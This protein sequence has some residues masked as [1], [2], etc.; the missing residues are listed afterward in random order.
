MDK[1]ESGAVCRRGVPSGKVEFDENGY[2]SVIKDYAKEVYEQRRK[3]KRLLIITGSGISKTPSIKK[4]M[5]KIQELVCSQQALEAYSEAFQRI[6]EEYDAC[7]RDVGADKDTNSGGKAAS[8]QVSAQSKLLTYIQNAYLSEMKRYVEKKDQEALKAVWE[9]FVLWLIEGDKKDEPGLL[10]REP[11]KAHEVIREMYREM[12]AVS[13]TTNFDNM[14]KK[15]FDEKPEEDESFYPLLDTEDFKRY[16][17]SC[18]RE[19]DNRQGMQRTEIQSRGDVFWMRCSG[20]KNRTCKNIGRQC[21]VPSSDEPPKDGKIVCRLCGSPVEI[22]FAFPGTKEKDHEMSRVMSGMWRFLALRCGAVLVVGSS[23]D[24]DPVLLKFLRE[25]L[26]REE[27]P[28]LYVSRRSVKDG[29]QKV[30]ENTA[31]RS[32]FSSWPQREE[33][34][35]YWVCGSDASDVLT[36]VLAAYREQKATGDKPTLAKQIEKEKR[37]YIGYAK[38]SMA[39]GDHGETAELALPVKKVH[40]YIQ[41]LKRYSQLGMKTYW[42]SAEKESGYP[43]HNRYKHS[44]GVAMTATAIYYAARKEKA[45]EEER[46][47]L[48]LAALLHDLGHLPFSHLIEEVFNEFG[49]VP[50]G[51]S[52]TFDHE[53]YTRVRIRQL[54]EDDLE[55][56][57]VLRRSGYT[58]TDLLRLIKGEFGVGYLDAIINGPVDADKIEYLF[59]DGTFTKRSHS[60]LFVNFL[61]DYCSELD[62]TEHGFLTISGNATKRVL[63]LIDLR[64]QM[65]RTLYLRSGL[66]YLE[67]CCKLII[68]TFIAYLCADPAIFQVWSN[69]G[70]SPKPSGLDW[71]NLSDRKI[72]HTL[73]WIRNMLEAANSDNLKS[74]ERYLLEQMQQYLETQNP[75]SA[76]MRSAI[77]FCMDKI[78]KTQS[79]EAVVEIEREYVESFE[80]DEKKLED[81]AL[82]GLLKRIYLRFPGV[83]LVDIVKSKS[84]FSFSSV[85]KRKKREDGTNE[86]VESVLIADVGGEHALKCFGDATEDIIRE[87][88]IPR[89]AYI[90]FYKITDEAYSYMQA[91]DYVKDQLRR[92]NIIQAE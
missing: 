76:T 85:G 77:R 42:L 12:D 8:E 61:T 39:D 71:V 88:S 52:G 75:L 59:S 43:E 22:Y 84:A 81:G 27:V 56:A 64:G 86:S 32:F 48:Q 47:F 14:L 4:M 45:T 63:E 6:Y 35:R 34:H 21:Y 51:E 19:G 57:T 87:L 11:T 78:T 46:N 60:N 54:M 62:T 74:S 83:I 13:I 73:R 79:E 10:K 92:L 24:Y 55:C 23:M 68:R 26:K 7:T 72:D 80:V 33:E 30:N 44:L 28:L 29:K 70:G 41:E 40:P 49:W 89:H 17:V 3:N 2:Q 67:A 31:T 37:D 16:F 82:D 50:A 90:N 5:E 9:A 36:D 58:E 66:R 18:D 91:V 1:T 25:L 38:K 53:Y 20:A 69:N 15:A 65:Y